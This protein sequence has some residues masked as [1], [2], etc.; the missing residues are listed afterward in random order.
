LLLVH[1]TK[2]QASFSSPAFL[3]LAWR[4]EGTHI[5]L[6]DPDRALTRRKAGLF[7]PYYEDQYLTA[8]RTYNY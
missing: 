8:L 6:E 3:F 7:T 5:S 1:G 4:Y 2:L